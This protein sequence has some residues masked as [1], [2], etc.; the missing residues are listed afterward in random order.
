ME[1]AEQRS[2][3]AFRIIQSRNCKS[4]QWLILCVRLKL[5][6]RFQKVRT[7]DFCALRGHLNDLISIL[8]GHI[9]VFTDDKDEP[10]ISAFDP[11]PL[12]VKYLSFASYQSASVEFLYN[13]A[14]DKTSVLSGNAIRREPA[15]EEWT[16]LS[17]APLDGEWFQCFC[18]RNEIILL[19]LIFAINRIGEEMPMGR[20]MGTF[21]Q[22]IPRH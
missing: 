18:P 15:T 8:V 22:R 1:T 16:S 21:V 19:R 5:S 7:I 6:L 10:L 14:S 11:N 3:N 20:E 9:R 4:H 2:V 13:C 17:D 12:P